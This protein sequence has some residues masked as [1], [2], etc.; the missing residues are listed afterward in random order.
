MRQL[1]REHIHPKHIIH[2]MHDENMKISCERSKE[3]YTTGITSILDG[4]IACGRGPAQG[5]SYGNAEGTSTDGACAGTISLFRSWRAGTSNNSS[6][7][8]VC[9]TGN[10]SN[11]KGS[12]ISNLKLAFTPAAGAPSRNHVNFQYS[13]TPHTDLKLTS[14]SAEPRL[15]PTERLVW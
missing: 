1:M 7:Q 6:L 12:N 14:K 3:N 9:H 10:I 13:V 15:P 5:A 2:L 11:H 8:L 4:R